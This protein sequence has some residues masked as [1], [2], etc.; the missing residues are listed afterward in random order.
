MSKKFP[1]RKEDFSA[2]CGQFPDLTVQRCHVAAL[3]RRKTGVEN[4]MTPQPPLSAD[5]DLDGLDFGPGPY[6]GP[7]TQLAG[8]DELEE[9]QTQE[10]RFG[11]HEIGLWRAAQGN[12]A[13]ELAALTFGVGQLDERLRQGPAGSLR[14]LAL[15]EVADLGWWAGEHV[16]LDRLILATE[17]RLAGVQDQS[18]ALSAMLWSVRR[19][20]QSAGPGND[21]HLIAGFLGRARPTDPPGADLRNLAAVL[22]RTGHLHPVVR[23]GLV[24]HLWRA[25]GGGGTARDLE[26]AVLGAK[27]AAGELTGGARFLPLALSSGAGLRGSGTPEQ[28]LAAWLQG[29]ARATSAALM[30]L[31]R[32]SDWRVRAAEHMAGLSGRT[33]HRLA[34]V[35]ADWPVVSAPLAERETGAS[36][37]AVQRNLDMMQ[38]RDLIREIT[39]QGRFRLW[40]V[41]L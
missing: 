16:G 22:T 29:A 15:M 41:K 33:P 24:F 40:T 12:L 38:G 27:V 1:D 25:L 8:H 39:G 2:D 20:V 11:D 5:D 36:R 23:G 28:R 3:F 18:L 31:D 35:F 34:A 19:L 6:D 7:Q 13:A 17:D 37:A 9:E 14:R 30:H 4:A 10:R 21:A 32:M 26:A